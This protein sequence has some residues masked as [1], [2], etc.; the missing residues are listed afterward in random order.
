MICMRCEAK[1]TL[2][3]AAFTPL[4]EKDQASVDNNLENKE[5]DTT[6]A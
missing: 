3:F 5:M 2:L 6:L 1:S 4:L